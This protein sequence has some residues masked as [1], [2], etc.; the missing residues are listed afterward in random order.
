M[1][2]WQGRGKKSNA[3][4][5]P[6]IEDSVW[7]HVCIHNPIRAISKR[8]YARCVLKATLLSPVIT[9]SPMLVAPPALRTA[10]ASL[11][12]PATGPPSLN[13]FRLPA[14][15]CRDKRRGEL[16]ISRR[17]RWRGGSLGRGRKRETRKPGV[18]GKWWEEKEADKYRC[19]Y[20]GIITK[21]CRLRMMVPGR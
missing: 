10:P 13:A 1:N 17:Q 5:S 8:L 6:D 16:R 4:K 19:Y 21:M 7:A 14:P 2:K 12:L 11:S 20:S 9:P 18:L 15:W 3:N